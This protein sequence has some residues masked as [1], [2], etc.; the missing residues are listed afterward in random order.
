MRR[1]LLLLAAAAALVAPQSADQASCQRKFNQIKAG[2]V[3]AGSKLAISSR[4]L[5]AYV[6]AQVPTVAPDGVREP[7]LELGNGRATGRAYVDFPK[8]RQ[9]QGQPMG[10]FMAKLLEG[11]KPV[12]VEA[13]II[14]GGGMATVDV[15][16]VEVS[17]LELSGSTLDY[18]I[19]RF[20]W[21][22]YPEAKIG[23][24]FEL[25]H[26]IDRL[27]IRPAGVDVVIA[28]KPTGWRRTAR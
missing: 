15:E 16:R 25:D 17:G 21:S 14:S 12:V 5:N 24:P 26:D 2:R 10:W 23:K 20:L 18:V 4:E 3:P 22:Y 1:I 6:R 13:R 9:S 19:R 11:E 8:L 28:P 27:E 7:R